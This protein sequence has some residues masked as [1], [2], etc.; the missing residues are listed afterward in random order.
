MEAKTSPLSNPDSL[1]YRLSLLF[2]TQKVT[3]LLVYAEL[4]TK[5][6][7]F[8]NQETKVAVIHLFTLALNKAIKHLP[9]LGEFKIHGN[10]M[11]S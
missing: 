4:I 7:E 10:V 3:S 11:V 5:V 2:P 8:K 9:D 1:D 6:L